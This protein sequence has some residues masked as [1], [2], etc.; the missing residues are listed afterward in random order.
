[1]EEDKLR[2]YIAQTIK[3]YFAEKGIKQTE[4]AERL[5]MTQAAVCKYLAGV[6][7]F[8]KRAAVK[9]SEALGFSVSFLIAGE[10]SLIPQH[11]N[12]S[13]TALADAS[14]ATAS[15][16]TGDGVTCADSEYIKQLEKELATAKAVIERLETENGKLWELAKNR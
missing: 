13:A 4:I 8:G 7:P 6:A 9:W 1:M 14:G 12:I 10:G 11:A 2:A 5:N 3:N 15:Y 16:K